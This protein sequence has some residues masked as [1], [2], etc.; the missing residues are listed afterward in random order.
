MMMKKYS[1]ILTCVVT[2]FI[3]GA[4]F[5][6]YGLDGPRDSSAFENNLGVWPSYATWSYEG[7][8]VAN[9]LHD[10]QGMSGSTYDE[11]SNHTSDGSV[12]NHTFSSPGAANSGHYDYLNNILMPSAVDGYTWEFRVKYNSLGI[13]ETSNGHF[14]AFDTTGDYQESNMRFRDGYWTGNQSQITFGGTAYDV[15]GSFSEWH[16]YRVAVLGQDVAG[17]GLIHANLY[18]DQTLIGS[19]SWAPSTSGS[20]VAWMGVAWG[21][22]IGSVDVDVDYFRVDG[23]GAYAPVPEPMT[24]ALLGLG[25][26]LG[27][28]RRK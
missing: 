21:W 7:G 15:P 3:S 1:V 24:M 14:W 17:D 13:Y 6:A 2:M 22:D 5:G 18:Q 20:A 23:T 26:L 12:K 4:T 11:E 19:H 28:R 9:A 8:T 16:N 25:G 10:M 27:L